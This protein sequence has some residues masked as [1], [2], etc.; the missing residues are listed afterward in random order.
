M[1]NRKRNSGFGFKRKN[2]TEEEFRTYLESKRL[3]DHASEMLEM[4]YPEDKEKKLRKT[5]TA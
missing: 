2:M 5:K 3:E 4:A 1:S